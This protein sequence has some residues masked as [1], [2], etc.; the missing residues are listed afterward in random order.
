MQLKG[1]PWSKVKEEVNRM[2]A[3]L[4]LEDKRDAAA[5]ELSGGMKRKLCVG[6]ALI[7]DSKVTTNYG[8]LNRFM[9][10]C[11]VSKKILNIP[12]CPHQ[13]PI[14]CPCRCMGVSLSRKIWAT[15]KTL[16]IN[17]YNVLSVRNSG[18][19]DVGNGSGGEKTDVGHSSKSAGW[20][21]NDP[22]DTFHG[23]SRPPW[24][25]HCHHG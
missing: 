24:R 17:L 11:T 19:A 5:K 18:R 12:S 22:V 7:A 21:H 2:I 4:H 1:C 6:I 9:L 15:L 23:R 20:T 25:S 10:H 8:S 14:Y 16:V 13:F 3:V